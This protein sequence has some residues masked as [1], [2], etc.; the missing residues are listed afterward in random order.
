M[1]LFVGLAGWAGAM[2]ILASYLLLSARRLNGNSATY[3]VM[4]LLGAAGI[5]ANSGWNGALPSAVLNV[6][7]AGIAVYAL[8]AHRNA[9]IGAP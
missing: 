1:T 8:I 5:A 6:I 3:H 7:W 9:Q 4:N 2:V